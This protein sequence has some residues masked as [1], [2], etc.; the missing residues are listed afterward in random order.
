[1]LRIGPKASCKLNKQGT[2]KG[3]G[4]KQPGNETQREQVIDTMAR[5][6]AWELRW[7][8]TMGGA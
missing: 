1:M 8:G 7:K 3:E 2:W 6:P 4:R 5:T